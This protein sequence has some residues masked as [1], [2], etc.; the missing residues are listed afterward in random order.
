[1]KH[2]FIPSTEHHLTI[3]LGIIVQEQIKNALIIYIE[4]IKNSEN[5]LF[6][7]E[8]CKLQDEYKFKFFSLNFA[9]RNPLMLSKFWRRFFDYRRRYKEIVDIIGD[10]PSDSEFY[11]FADQNAHTQFIINK[12]KA[13]KF[14]LAQE[15]FWI[16]VDHKLKR[17]SFYKRFYYKILFGKFWK[18][19]KTIGSRTSYK[20]LYTLYPN[21]VHSRYD[22]TK[23]IEIT[24]ENY[25]SE[26]LRALSISLLQQTFPQFFTLSEKDAFIFLPRIDTSKDL[27]KISRDLAKV[28][29]QTDYE[30]IFLKNH[31]RSNSK[32]DFSSLITKNLSC[33]EVPDGIPAECLF[34]FNN[35]ISARYFLPFSTLLLVAGLNSQENQVFCVEYQMQKNLITSINHNVGLKKFVERFK[36]PTMRNLS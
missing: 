35:K 24:K 21:M 5:R 34:I 3:C 1:M 30:R 18:P 4:D 13:C 23:V 10:I 9:K 27:K 33:I 16:Y 17:N 15:G 11:V 6:F 25:L 29:A 14:N 28:F 12:Y 2:I 36:I 19:V 26:A 32:L 31:P 8:F 7:N 22:Q 20:C